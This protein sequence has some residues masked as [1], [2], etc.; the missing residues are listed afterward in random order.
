MTDSQ[1]LRYSPI[2]KASY[3]FPDGESPFIGDST[4][5]PPLTSA[6]LIDSTL[7][8]HLFCAFADLDPHTHK[9]VVSSAHDY[10]FSTFTYTV[11]QKNSQVQTL[12][13]IGGKNADKSAFAA[14]ASYQTSRK[15]FIDSSIEIARKGGFH[16]L[17]LAWEYPSNDVE[18]TNFGKLVQEWRVAIKN[19]SDLTDRLPLL[20]TAAVYYSSDYNSA[21]Y[22]IK[23]IVDNLDW[24]NLIAYDF[25]GPGWSPVTGPTAALFDHSKPPGPS[26]DGGLKKWIEAG[27]PGKKAVLGF[28]YVGWA[29]SLQDVD[30]NGY[31]APTTGAALSSDGSINYSQVR[32]YIVDNGAA[33]THNQM[34]TGDYCY[35]GPIWIGY[36]DNQTVVHK[37]KYAKHK[38]LLGYY[39]WHVGADYNCG[40]SRAASRAWDAT[41]T[42]TGE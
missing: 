4:V 24:V 7:F 2:V 25:Y 28:P 5:C 39:S 19:E 6:V 29:W 42:T 30:E 22:P 33:V 16:G 18:M 21:S 14:M 31:D 32:N 23:E 20:L 26:A 15:A 37:V 3:W 36:D 40:L 11:K 1:I 35:A 34:V 12:L 13:S 10:I 38:G 41:E 8:T 27:L 17:D 9:V